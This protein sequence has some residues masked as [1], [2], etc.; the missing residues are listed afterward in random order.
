MALV[1]AVSVGLKFPLSGLWEATVGKRL[2]HSIRAAVLGFLSAGCELGTAAVAFEWLLPPGTAWHAAAFGTGVGQLEMVALLVVAAWQATKARD[3]QADSAGAP[4]SGDVPWHVR[5]TFIVERASSLLGHVGSRG[6]VWLSL[7]GEPW[8]FIVAMV[9]FAL[10]DGVAAYGSMRH[11]DWLSVS[12]WKRFYG[13]IMAIGL[14][15]VAL[16]VTLA[17][18]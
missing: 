17:L 9:T 11:W 15:E 14:V 18:A 2:S 10:V 13:F 12:I 3:T 6:L 8:T 5:W 7:H 1:W 4:P 16:F